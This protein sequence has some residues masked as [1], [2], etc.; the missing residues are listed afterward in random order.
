MAQH[1]V[2]VY[3]EPREMTQAEWIEDRVNYW[4]SIHKGRRL[5]M[6]TVELQE[7]AGGKVVIWHI[8]EKECAFTLAE[9]REAFE[10]IVK[11]E[12]G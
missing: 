1:K 3:K 4:S 2:R 10:A 8:G 6:I 7:T 9:W 12:G 11:K 5:K